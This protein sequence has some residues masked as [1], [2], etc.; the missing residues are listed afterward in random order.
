MQG[1]ENKIEFLLNL[2]PRKYDLDRMQ[3]YGDTTEGYDEFYKRNEALLRSFEEAHIDWLMSIALLIEKS[4]IKLMD[5]EN[6][7]H[8]DASG[9]YHTKEGKLCIYNNS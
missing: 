2:L 4:E 9:M 1:I 3:C 8:H 7:Y 5:M 6:C